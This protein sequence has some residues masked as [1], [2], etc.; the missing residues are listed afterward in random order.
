MEKT[1][2]DICS[3]YTVYRNCSGFKVQSSRFRGSKV[4]GSEVQGSEVQG[5]SIADL[6]FR[7]LD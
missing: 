7:I 6:G 1:I 5:P 2:V 3:L 4:Q